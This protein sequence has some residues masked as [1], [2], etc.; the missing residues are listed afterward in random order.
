M[1]LRFTHIVDGKAFLMEMFSFILLVDYIRP[2]MSSG[3]CAGWCELEVAELDVELVNEEQISGGIIFEDAWS[4]IVVRQVVICFSTF[5]QI[6]WSFK[7]MF[8][9]PPFLSMLRKITPRQVS[10]F[11][12]TSAYKLKCRARDIKNFLLKQS[13][14]TTFSYQ[15]FEPH[16]Q[17]SCLSIQSRRSTPP[18]R[19]VL[20]ILSRFTSY[21]LFKNI[22]ISLNFVSLFMT[23][24]IAV[25]SSS[26][27]TPVTRS[28]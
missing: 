20:P 23:L 22:F 21:K 6:C 27:N 19:F 9:Q 8:R 17:F 2:K 13:A 16:N 4:M 5:P 11:Q 18:S 26:F 3:S 24:K 28:P 15:T 12:I 10:K 1:F 7:E 25:V 14:I